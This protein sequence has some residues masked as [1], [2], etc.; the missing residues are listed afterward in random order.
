VLFSNVKVD[1]CCTI[2]E[3]GLM[4]D[5]VIR[6]GSRLTKEVVDRGCVLPEGTVIGEDAEEDAR[7]FHRSETGVVLVTPEML[8]RA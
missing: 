5:T 8:T 6:R 2:H 4:P 7:R 1:A 3:A